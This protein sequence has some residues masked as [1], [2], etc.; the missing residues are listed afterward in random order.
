MN[1]HTATPIQ[2][3]AIPIILDGKDLI[4]V[5]QTGTGKTAAFMLPV[6]NM[7]LDHPRS[8][9]VQALI[10]VPTRE[11]AMQI[12]KAIEAYAYF[13]GTS[14]VAV[15][16]GGD[17]KDFNRE[18]TAF[19]GGVDIVIATPGRLIAH[20]NLGYVNFTKLRFLILDE[21]DRMLD[22]G[23][24]ADLNKI[25]GSTNGD[26]QTLLFSATMSPTVAKLAKSL[27]RNPETVN[28]G[29]AK[30]A[31]GVT[32]SVYL[33]SEDQ[34]M[35]LVTK[36]LKE[37]TGKS[38]IVFS[39]TKITVTKLFQRL[40]AKGLSVDRI[41][42]D[43]EQSEREEVLMRFRNR[44]VDVL[45]ATDVMSRGID[46]DGIDIV[47]NYD[48]PRDAEDYVHRVGRTARAERKGEAI[49]LVSAEENY[50]FRR[51][52]TL[53]GS[54]IPRKALPEEIGT[55]P[56]PRAPRSHTTGSK[57]RQ[58]RPEGKG[59]GS[60]RDKRNKPKGP[61]SGPGKERKV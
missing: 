50:K 15:Y 24:Q 32:Q 46:I 47:I 54:E 2:E 41:S 48:L 22:M 14:S 36:I 5:A 6:L 43:L 61:G 40:K 49:T 13:T 55:S 10:L 56:A 33:V 9:H 25:I 58:G 45:V 30:P 16:G 18:K 8:K 31:E 19:T 4:G 11:L 1:F 38:T 53:I 60:F 20:M 57:P 27:M 51:I 7:L 42:S 34:K 52:E 35:P 12:D 26:R 59:K 21:A 29:M 23:F 17:G 39:S 37:N 3:K 44:Q 28:M